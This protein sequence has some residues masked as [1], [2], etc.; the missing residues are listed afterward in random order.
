MKRKSKTKYNRVQ[1]ETELNESTTLQI[2]N[3]HEKLIEDDYQKYLDGK[4]SK[5]D[6]QPKGVGVIGHLFFLYLNKV[7]NLGLKKRY[8]LNLLFK[9]PDVLKHENKFPKFKKYY[10]EQ[11]DQ[12]PQVSFLRVIL[13][14]QFWLWL[15][16]SL[17]Y[18]V[19]F[20]FQLFLPMAV[21]R[22]LRWLTG[23]TGDGGHQESD[24]VGIISAIALI[25]ISLIKSLGVTQAVG[26]S[27]TN[28]IVI[29]MLIRV[30][31]K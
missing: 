21:K 15:E 12:K 20:F 26:P 5:V 25:L 10:E 23:E 29:E 8:E 9:V 31:S 6:Y 3:E 16:G 11:F 14:F 18:F 13:G 4:N 7:I 2:L 19:P 28:S 24:L 17:K 1:H 27:K 30:S 22:Y